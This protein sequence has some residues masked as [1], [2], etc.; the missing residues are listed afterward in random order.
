MDTP[1]ATDTAAEIANNEGVF[2]FRRIEFLILGESQF[3]D[4]IVIGKILEAAVT[5][6]LADEAVVFAAG[7]KE[8]DIQLPGGVD[9]C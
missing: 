5:A 6:G 2:I 9:P 3:F 7:Q 8:F 1:A 4:P